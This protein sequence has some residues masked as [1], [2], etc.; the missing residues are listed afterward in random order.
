MMLLDTNVFNNRGFL[1]WIG[2]KGGEVY[3]SSIS[4]MELVYH[5]LKKG[6]PEG[7]TLSVFKALKIEIVDFDYNAA[8]EGA[9]SAIGKWDLSEH[10]PDY[11]ILGIAKTLKATLVTENKEDFAY[12]KVNTPAEIMR[13]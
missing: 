5:H 1:D 3:V 10:A 7:Y 6:T 11:A 4:V 8:L 13:G 9:K 2:E 12:E